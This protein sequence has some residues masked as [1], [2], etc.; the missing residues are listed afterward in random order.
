MQ[1]ARWLF[2][3]LG[4]AC[5][6]G[7]R[8]SAQ[9]VISPGAGPINKAMAGASTAAPVDF[10]S[11]YWNPANISFL[12][13]DEVLLGSELI[14]PDVY[15]S[16]RIPAG[17]IDGVQPTADRAGTTRSNS[18]V[19]SNLAVGGTFRLAPDSPI[20]FG[21]G[22]FGLVGGGVNFPGGYNTPVLAPR[23]PP[24]F[25]GV[26]P[27]YANMALLS[28]KPM[29][30]YQMTDRLAVAIAPV[31]STG[32]VQFDPA[33]FAPGPKDQYGLSTFPAG[34]HAHTVWGGG[35]E[36][37]LLYALSD[38]WNVGF[39]YKSPIWQERWTYRSSN[40]DLSPRTLGLQAQIPAIYSW[41]VAYKGLPKTLIDVDF[42]YLDYANT[43]MFGTPII[44][45]GLNW[46]SVFAVALGA[47]YEA[48]ERLTLRAGYLYNTNPI[49]APQ[50][51]FNI[52]APGFLQHTF[53]I[54]ASLR[55]AEHIVTSIAW[56]HSF[57]NS[58][59]GPILQIPNSTATLSG[60][61][62]SLLAG[63][64]IQYGPKRKSAEPSPDPT[65]EGIPQSA[66]PPQPAQ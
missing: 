1:V 15:F 5:L 60:Q 42:R 53:S 3:V 64:T 26:G 27:I 8:T 66:I 17:A 6:C 21:L 45:G 10:G 44:D 18:G 52:Q 30:S 31:V 46:K 25:V 12:Q 37:G 22:I 11:S 56:S 40:P 28:I 43:S 50:T 59:T 51:L 48:S 32:S 4:L 63:V 62:D 34:T 24:V 16:S 38:A 20:T 58:I 57:N 9:G 39:S 33:F 19:A 47:Q 7:S 55:L 23:Q 54:G 35:F 41:G 49:D 36:L 2:F 29:V 65:V 14:L 61:A 13:R